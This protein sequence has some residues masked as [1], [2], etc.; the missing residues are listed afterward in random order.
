M[1]SVV[2]PRPRSATEILD[3]SVRLVRAHYGTLVA[4][5]ALCYVPVA[6]IQMVFLPTASPFA[7]APKPTP[8]MLLPGLAWT[9]F[10]V[11]WYHATLTS[12]VTLAVSDIYLRGTTQL[13]AV[14]AGMVR[15]FPPML[16]L[17]LVG[18]GVFVLL[19]L[20]CAV[21]LAVVDGVL[22]SILRQRL[23]PLAV[24]IVDLVPSAVVFAYAVAA[25]LA[26]V[27]IVVLEGQ[28]PIA[29]LRRSIL[30]TKELRGHVLR[31]VGLVYVIYLGLYYSIFLLLHA[32]GAAAVLQ[33]VA[34]LVTIVA[35][36]P[37]VQTPVVALYYDLRIRKEGY[38]V[39]LMVAALGPAATPQ[40]A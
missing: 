5:T 24:V 23:N 31:V 10:S 34:N 38:D 22:A 32:A 36:Y 7:P 21:P 8:R 17:A 18:A 4:L 16:G 30:L 20:G 26:A 6:L 39:E 15:R 37:F 35:L 27:P 19:V 33:H 12:A 14:L 13:R 3:A 1:S 9:V 2:L 28:G 29:A 40:I 25:L 11:I